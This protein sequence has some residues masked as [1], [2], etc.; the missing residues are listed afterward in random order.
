MSCNPETYI[1]DRQATHFRVALRSQVSKNLRH[2]VSNVAIIIEKSIAQGKLN[3]GIILTRQHLPDRFERDMP[4]SG[5][6]GYQ[7]SHGHNLLSDKLN[8]IRSAVGYWL[9]YEFVKVLLNANGLCRFLS[10]RNATLT[11]GHNLSPN[12]LS[13]P[14]SKQNLAI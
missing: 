10:A 7:S 3:Q 11:V 12:A 8:T 5:G 4:R 14:L 1:S 2:C 9:E 13:P 6:D